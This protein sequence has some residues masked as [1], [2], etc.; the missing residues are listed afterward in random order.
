MSIEQIFQKL[1]LTTNHSAVYLAALELGPSSIQEIA[2]KAPVKRSTCYLL[3]ED[4]IQKGLMFK[5][6]RGKKNLFGAE[7][8]EKIE[9]LLTE[10]WREA[11]NDLQEFENLLPQLKFLHSKKAG[12][13]KIRFY[14]GTEGIKSI[15][16]DTLSASEIL[17][18]CQGGRKERLSEEPK[19]LLNYLSEVVAHGIK[20]REII[21]KSPADRQYQQKY[22][23]L[24]NQILLA[25]PTNNPN[26]IHI[27]KL[28]YDDKI[29][30]ISYE[31]KLGVVIEDKFLA[32][33]ERVSFNVLWN[34]LQA[35]VYR[36][37]AV[38]TPIP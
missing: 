31:K 17:V 10:L 6:S 37:S 33:N 14:D 5:T 26:L 12:K 8:P 25:P 13:P 27:D 35:K 32:A 3:T 29:A 30:F 34:A 18:L 16:A 24:K 2:K 15:F 11:Q 19:Y 21:E 7:N 38:S 4:L 22:S 9:Q 28:I 1:N 36:Y 20:T 23:T